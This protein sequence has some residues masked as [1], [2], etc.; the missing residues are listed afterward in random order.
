MNVDVKNKSLLISIL[1]SAEE[2]CACGNYS[3][4]KELYTKAIRIDDNNP[5]FYGNR[6]VVNHYLK[7]YQNALKDAEISIHVDP[8]YAMV[9][10]KS[11]KLVIY[12]QNRLF[13]RATLFVR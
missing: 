10:I 4:A 12:T 3:N 5:A 11:K 9:S 6:S 2:A 8:E 7:D 13:H 1:Q